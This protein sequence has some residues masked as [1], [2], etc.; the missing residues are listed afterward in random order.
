MAAPVHG[1]LAVVQRPQGLAGGE[2]VVR[3]LHAPAAD[4]RDAEL[5]A[6]IGMNCFEIVV[7]SPPHHF[8][9]GHAFGECAGMRHV[10]EDR[11]S[12]LAGRGM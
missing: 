6:N 3:Q 7:V 11:R 8:G 1:G 5:H 9:Q 2:G 10:F 12:F 4:R